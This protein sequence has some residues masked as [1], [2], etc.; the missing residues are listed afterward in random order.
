MIKQKKSIE[1]KDFQSFTNNILKSNCYI[2]PQIIKD[3]KGSKKVTYIVQPI[4]EFFYKTKLET[5]KREQSISILRGLIKERFNI[6]LSQNKVAAVDA[7]TGIEINEYT[8][9]LPENLCLIGA[10]EKELQKIQEEL[11]GSK[12]FPQKLLFS[13]LLIP[14]T[15]DDY[16]KLVDFKG[17]TLVVD[18]SLE[19]SYVYMVGQG[20]ILA[21][22][23]PTHGLKNIMNLCRKECN[24][25][26]DISV[27]K[28]L[29][30]EIKTNPEAIKSLAQRLVSDIKSYI[31][32]FEVQSGISISNLYVTNLLDSFEW[33]EKQLSSEL[34]LPI[35]DIDYEQ[36]LKSKNIVV[37][38]KI[39]KKAS[40]KIIFGMM[41]AVIHL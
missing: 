37:P 40:K 33:I 18:F 41:S 9:V 16:S 11:L 8:K 17:T 5:K 35:F 36:W 20:K 7:E 26:D 2:D 1:V 29:S 34:S 31:D 15:F 25:P 32:F 22:Y 6:D 13:S 23:P 4:S 19:R 21:A 24:L 10:Q 27:L 3:V 30:S 12:L 28:Y 14:K 38:E 39:L